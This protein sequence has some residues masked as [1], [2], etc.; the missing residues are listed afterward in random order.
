[1]L[2]GGAEQ[3]IAPAERGLKRSLPGDRAALGADQQPEPVVQPA[4]QLGQAERLG[5]GRGKFDRQRQ[6]VK[7]RHQP[8][9]HGT[10]L[11]VQGEVRVELSGPV[12]EQRHRLRGHRVARAAPFGQRQR[13]SAGSQDPDVVGGQQHRRAELRRRLQHVLAV[14]ED[15]Q[16]LLAGQVRAKRFHDRHPGSLAQAK[17]RG[18]RGGH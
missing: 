7:A 15:Q 11:V 1:M 14:V 13:L 4:V 9:H 5:T 17:Y 10:R 8:G 3:L 6:P 12:N 18:C 2:L 16:Q